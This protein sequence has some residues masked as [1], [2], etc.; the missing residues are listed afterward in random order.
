MKIVDVPPSSG[1]GE[2]IS[3]YCRLGEGAKI[4]TALTTDPRFT[5]ADSVAADG[6]VTGPYLVVTTAQGQVLRIPLAG[7]RAPSTVKG[8]QYVKLAD[9]DRVVFVQLVREEPGV[10]L[11]SAAGRVLHFP[12]AEVNTVAGPAKGVI[13]IKLDDGDACIGGALVKGLESRLVV[14]TTGG[15]TMEFTS[16]QEVASRGGKGFE[17]VKRT[18]FARV[19]PPAIA[20]ADWDAVEAQKE[21]PAPG[22]N[23]DGRPTLFE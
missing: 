21:E 16:R 20:L 15:K 17:A 14:E 23:G 22:G 19:V 7:F 9:G 6:E 18:G 1:Y 2:P 5:P 8:R 4:L 12:V 3:K 13:G 11:A 10:M